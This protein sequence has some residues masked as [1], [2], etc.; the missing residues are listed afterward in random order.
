MMPVPTIESL[1]GKPWAIAMKFCAQDVRW[2][3]E[4]DVFTHTKMVLASLENLSEFK[5]LPE[6]QRHIVYWAALLHDVGK[7]VTTCEEEDGSIT[8]RKHGLVGSRIARRILRDAGVSVRDRELICSLIRF[9]SSPIFCLNDGETKAI[10]LSWR[11]N[12]WLLYILAMA[13]DLGRDTDAHNH[14]DSIELFRILCEDNNCLHQPYAFPNDQARFLFFNGGVPNLFYVPHE[15]YSCRA[16]MMAG[17]PGAGKSTWRKNS[18]LPV[19]SLDELRLELKMAPGDYGGALPSRVKD[20]CQK[21]LRAHQDF[22]FDATNLIKDHRSRW[23][24]LFADYG[25]R[26]IGMYIEPAW[27][28]ILKQN[29]NRKAVVPL[30]VINS[31][32]DSME[33]PTIA[34]FHEFTILP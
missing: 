23:I 13:D 15:E 22:V 11:T 30:Y 16:I 31:M 3:A 14:G 27:E 33:P 7:P 32:F 10:E 24:R 12:C 17:L 5:D 21:Y 9:H 25:A 34:E 28:T 1:S 19:V 20:L 18:N 29:Q 8:S 2:H 6:D 26:T 4:G